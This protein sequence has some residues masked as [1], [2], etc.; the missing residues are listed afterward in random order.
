MT[1]HEGRPVEHGM[2]GLA[3]PLCIIDSEWTSGAPDSARLVQLC[4][5]RLEPGGAGV[6]RVWSINPEIPIEAGAQ[7]VHGI[8]DDDVA[9][10]PPF[11]AL[12]GDVAAMLAGADVGGYSIGGDLAILERQLAEC[13]I[14]WH[15]EKLAIVD[16]IRIWQRREPRA[17]TDAY[18][19][20]CN[21][22][23][24][25]D[26]HDAAA[27]VA[28]TA[29]V[30][31]VQ[32]AEC[33]EEHYPPS[34]GGTDE[35]GTPVEPTWHPSARDL[36][37]EALAGQLDPAGKFKRRDDGVIIYSF[38][39]HRLQPVA[40]HLDF[41]E[42]MMGKDFAPSTKRIAARLFDRRGIL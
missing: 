8:A 36:H 23:P 26:A 33:P 42:W 40:D 3:R 9:D 5:R 6:E 17:L 1:G 34:V 22:E 29:A 37:D 28:M 2:T 30:I 25:Q 24:D 41:I 7:A 15:V 10:W 13:G 32:A 16:A 31:E 14:G 27:D 11:G 12:A 21:A 18:R 39:P 20:W 4:I 19:H 38:G 35:D